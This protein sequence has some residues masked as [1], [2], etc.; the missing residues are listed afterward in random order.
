MSFARDEWMSDVSSHMP[1]RLG[2]IAEPHARSTHWSDGALLKSPNDVCFSCLS[3][4]HYD[5][6]LIESSTN[7]QGNDTQ[8]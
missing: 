1:F 8:I 4:E 7:G 3:K 5:R 6:G 2:G